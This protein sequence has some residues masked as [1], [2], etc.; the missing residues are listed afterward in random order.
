[1]LLEKPGRGA[2][3]FLAGALCGFTRHGEQYYTNVSSCCNRAITLKPGF[4]VNE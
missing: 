4:R 1:L 3:N 2:K